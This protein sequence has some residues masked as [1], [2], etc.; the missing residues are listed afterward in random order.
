MGGNSSS[1][2]R[3]VKELGKGT[4]GVTYLV[5]DNNGKTYALKTID[6]LKSKENGVSTEDIETEILALTKLSHDPKCY[7][8]IACY[9]DSGRQLLNQRDTIWI[10]MEYVNGPT[11]GQILKNSRT[12]L[13]TN[14]L[15]NYM[16]QLTSAIDYIHKMG[17]AHRDIKPDNIILDT[18][19]NRVK[20]VD[21]GF[22]CATNCKNNVGTLLWMPPEVLLRKSPF[23][24]RS[25]KA[26]DIWSLGVVLYELANL[27]LPYHS[28]GND[29]NIIIT[30]IAY[31]FIPSKYRSDN[32]GVDA[33]INNIINSMLTRNWL[34]RPTS[35]QLLNYMQTQIRIIDG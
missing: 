17:Y 28:F 27:H 12:L 30:S 13:S 29:T 34:R 9:F 24:L 20:I 5:K 25:A 26:Q 23:T 22:A 6:V 16:Y 10:L 3:Y 1:K 2:L 7:P 19:N 11:F 14:T 33:V 35:Q 31:S 8:Y 15:W 18:V 21:F 32:P 4:F